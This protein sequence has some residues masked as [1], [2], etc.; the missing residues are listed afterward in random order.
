M[1]QFKGPND[2]KFSPEDYSSRSLNR[3]K[4]LHKLILII[5]SWQFVFGPP[6]ALA[7]GPLVQEALAPKAPA[8]KALEQEVSAKEPVV[9]EKALD[10]YTEAL[11]EAMVEIER[12]GVSEDSKEKIR[13]FLVRAREDIKKG[14]GIDPTRI[15]NIYRDIKEQIDSKGGRGCLDLE[16]GTRQ[17]ES[18]GTLYFVQK[19]QRELLPSLFKEL[20]QVREKASCLGANF[21]EGR[22]VNLAAQFTFINQLL[23]KLLQMESQSRQRDSLTPLFNLYLMTAIQ[24]V[25]ESHFFNLS[26]LQ[27]SF[28][29]AGVPFH[30]LGDL[31]S[32]AFKKG[33]IEKA[34]VSAL[35]IGGLSG[36][37]TAFFGSGM[38]VEKGLATSVS[39]AKKWNQWAVPLIS[40]WSRGRLVGRIE[41]LEKASYVLSSSVI[42]ALGGASVQGLSLAAETLRDASVQSFA[43]DSNLGAELI[44]AIEHEMNKAKILKAVGHGAAVGS[45]A[46]ATLTMGVFEYSLPKPFSPNLIRHST[47]SVLAAAV[48]Y[49]TGN[50][51]WKV[52]KS[53]MEGRR[54]L[55]ESGDE[56]Q[57][58]D[59]ETDSA[60]R[61]QIM[62]HAKELKVKAYEAFGNAAVSGLD[63]T[64]LMVLVNEL[65]VH[66]ELYHI[67][68]A[69]ESKVIDAVARGSDE[70]PSAATNIQQSYQGA[71]TGGG[72]G[73]V[74]KSSKLLSELGDDAAKLTGTK[75]AKLTDAADDSVQAFG[76]KSSNLIDAADDTAQVVSAKLPQL[77]EGA[78]DLAHLTMVKASKMSD[79]SDDVAA[80]IT[81]VG[82]GV[83]ASILPSLGVKSGIVSS[84]GYSTIPTIGETLD[85]M[86]TFKPLP[87]L[88]GTHR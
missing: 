32:E 29:R 45:I 76:L 81:G 85:H 15:N 25:A 42:G 35:F 80:V 87:R 69:H 33:L 16:Y 22:P 37:L 84:Q 70:V 27:H 68:N 58:L 49:S 48:L 21:S 63:L 67:W 47:L 55:S 38:I 8:P 51:G 57:K 23:L 39:V 75:S 54:Y 18:L 40:R 56:I 13:E 78:D 79:I 62:I 41:S 59:T 36:F 34:K 52:L 77:T 26:R 44:P 11:Y 6:M 2:S 72:D 74:V 5:L 12:E 7:Q 24:G 46:G 82:S 31:K 50:S 10:A 17:I 20:R 83:K 73:L 65:F 88:S 28:A 1:L 71:S 14:G 19:P 30:D 43:R 86:E 66:G 60:R 3:G 61:S 64:I 9:S 4:G 53:L